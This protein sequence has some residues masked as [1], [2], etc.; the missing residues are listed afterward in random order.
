MIYRKKI[1]NNI[2][3]N[4]NNENIINANINYIK[5]NLSKGTIIYIHNLVNIV[6][7]G[8]KEINSKKI[9]LNGEDK[10]FQNIF[11]EIVNMP[12]DNNENSDEKDK[13]YLDCFSKEML[14]KYL[15]E[16]LNI[17]ISDDELKLLFIRFDKLRR[18]KIK[19]LEFS[20]EMKYI[21]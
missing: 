16:K 3:E 20:D 6:I 2:L 19:F 21:I 11:E 4:S 14:Y 17:N 8:E 7:K 5:M 13:I 10:Y 9:E 18:G 15:I 12:D 1:K